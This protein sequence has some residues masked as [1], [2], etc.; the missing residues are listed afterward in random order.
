MRRISSLRLQP[1]RM[2][3]VA[4]QSSSAGCE[5]DS[6]LVPKS[7]GVRTRPVPK[8]LLQIWF[9]A[10]RLVSGCCG[11][12]SHSREIEAA[13]ASACAGCVIGG[14]AERLAGTTSGPRRV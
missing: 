12:T 11:E 1:L 5:G 7:S 2:N 6:P 14:S 10:T 8:S 9:T 4:S 3:S 13:S